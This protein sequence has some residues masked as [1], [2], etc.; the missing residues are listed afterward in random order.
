[1]NKKTVPIVIG[2]IVFC[3]LV[4]A[5][6]SLTEN[7]GKSDAVVSTE[8][9]TARIE[10]MA[11]DIAPATAQPVKSAVEYDDEEESK[12]AE[13]PELKDDTI[14]VKAD[15]AL[16]AEIFASGEKSGTG[17]DG[18]INEMAEQFNATHP[19]INGKEGS[20]QIRK[21]SSGLGLDYIA[22]GKSVPAG[23]TP[24]NDLWTKMLEAQGVK[25]EIVSDRLVGNTAGIVF[26]KD[27][28]D[29]MVGKYGTVNVKSVTEAVA[30]GEIQFGYTN[31]FTSATGMNWLIST[32][33]YYD[34]KNPLSDKA[35]QGFQEFQSNVPFVSLTTQQ[36]RDAAQRSA[37]D[38][39]VTE[40]QVYVN[41]PELKSGYVF[42]PFGV[43]HDNPLVTFASVDKDKKD[44][45]K[46]FADYCSENGSKLAQDDGFNEKDSYKCED[47]EV[48]GK[49]LVAA[50]KLYKANKDGSAPVVCVFVTDVSG[51]MEGA[52]IAELKQSLISSMK[53]INNQNYIGLVSYSDS[54]TI[55]LPIDKFDLNHQS[56]FKGAVESLT[57]A[58]ATAT[59][60][61]IIVAADLIRQKMEEVPNAKPMI[62]V[63]LDGDTNRGYTLNDV[64][65]QLQALHYPVY[66]IGY[67]ADIDALQKISEINEAASINAS[68]D[69]VTY[70]LKTLF[71]ANM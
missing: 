20:I 48:D 25:V 32:L 43:R 38:G 35:T 30:T 64:S 71:N 21:V 63:L 28:Q 37:L 18:W 54:V 46:Q 17:T 55:E 11:R 36:M 15:T 6:L 4:F 33:L 42:T 10:D 62:F 22:S 69:D 50:E 60:D 23:Y 16:Y 45:L 29:E 52:P 2:I 68:T 41:D 8:Q 7:F 47:P 14:T 51:S 70:Q 26:R 1:M 34:A 49:T 40:Y 9:A 44:L 24:S 61:G 59:F 58:G 31:P 39:F 57:P 27:K 19:T 56:Y 13:L 66:T 67:N 65:S 5:G 53:Y 12:A 3:L